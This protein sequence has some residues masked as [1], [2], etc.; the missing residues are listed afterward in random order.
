MDGR[1]GH[2]VGDLLILY[3]RD[4]PADFQ[5]SMEEEKQWRGKSGAC[6]VMYGNVP[7]GL[8]KRD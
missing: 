7:K 2:G 5:E 4:E 8:D 3:R 1:K 6:N